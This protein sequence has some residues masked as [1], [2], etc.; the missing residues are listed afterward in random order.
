LSQP[1]WFH[2]ISKFWALRRLACCPVPP[3]LYFCLANN[4]TRAVVGNEPLLL[5]DLTTTT[6]QGVPSEHC[7]YWALKCLR[8]KIRWKSQ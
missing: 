4:A 8:R 3:G 6:F 2:I 5:P 7:Y 1:A